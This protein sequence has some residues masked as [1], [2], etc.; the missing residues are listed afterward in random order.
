MYII[1]TIVCR[2]FIVPE[3]NVEF[4]Q[5]VLGFLFVLLADALLDCFSNWSVAVVFNLNGI[6]VLKNLFCQNTLPLF[7]DYFF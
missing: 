4:G 7:V 6:K 3:R 1:V 5:T 2:T